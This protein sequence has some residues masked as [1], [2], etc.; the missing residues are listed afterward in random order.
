VL[1]RKLLARVATGLPT[2]LP[3]LR[4]LVGPGAK[5]VLRRAAEVLAVVAAARQVAAEQTYT[6]P[7]VVLRIPAGSLFARLQ[8]LH[9][10][11][12]SQHRDVQDTAFAG[13]AAKQHQHQLCINDSM[14]SAD[15]PWSSA[16]RRQMSGCSRRRP[17]RSGR[18][19]SSQ[20]PAQPRKPPSLQTRG[21]QSARSCRH[22]ASGPYPRPAALRCRRTHQPSAE[23]AVSQCGRRQAP[24]SRQRPARRRTARPTS[25]CRPPQ[26]PPPGRRTRQRR[27]RARGSG[28]EPCSPSRTAAGAD[29]LA[30][31]PPPRGRQSSRGSPL[32]PRQQC[33]LCCMKHQQQQ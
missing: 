24:S 31:R 2:S 5:V 7:P 10:F 12:T 6:P 27:R 3:A 19:S 22:G 20:V 17:P 14:I 23:L 21:Q 4:E 8:Q 1:P 18:Q 32:Q 11:I 28:H 15:V 30:G 16:C 13:L 33:S 9:L 26:L 25:E 29:C